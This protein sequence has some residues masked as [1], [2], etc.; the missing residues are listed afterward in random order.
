MGIRIHDT[1]RREKVEFHPIVPGRVSMYVCG[2][3]VYDR[4]HLGHARCYLAFDLV[5]RW[6]ERSGY[7]VHYVQNFTDI[8]DKIIHRALEEGVPWQTLVQMNIEAYFQDMDALNILRADAYPR[9]TDYVDAMVRITED[10]IEKDHAYVTGDGVYFAVSSAPAKFGALTGQSFDAV[11]EGAGGRTGDE[12]TSKRDHRD[13]ALW[14][15]AKP[16]EPTWTSPWGPGRPGWHI[17]CT[18]MSL[19]HLGA[20]FDL[21]GGGHDLRFPHHEAEIMQGEC[22]TGTEPIV[23]IWM[24]NGFVNVDGEKMSKSLDNFWTIQEILADNDPLVLRLAL[25]NASYRAPIDMNPTLLEDAAN[26]HRRL[27]GILRRCLLCSESYPPETALDLPEGVVGSDMDL[28]DLLGRLEELAERFAL[29][30]DDDFNS[31][32]A[33]AQVLA[34]VKLGTRLLDLELNE[35]TKGAVAHHLLEWF[36]DHAGTVLGILPPLDE[37]ARPDPEALRLEEEVESLLQDRAHARDAKDWDEADRIRDRL[38]AMGIQVT[39]GPD[40]PTWSL[41]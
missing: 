8:D 9:C 21:H 22:H 35:D 27:L 23:G 29:A 40:G 7:D 14:K 37:L 16:D 31:R 18:A 36:S 20:P 12:A 3:T 28:V 11:Q 15:A 6:L 25:I 39:D 2:V 19:D 17:E 32:V 24:H 38:K 10:L 26:H 34:A 4:C 30:M 1:R 5:H 13:F 41:L 33:V